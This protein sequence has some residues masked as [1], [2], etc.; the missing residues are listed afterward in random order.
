M[1][2][3]VPCCEAACSAHSSVYACSYVLFRLVFCVLLLLGPCVCACTNARGG[4]CV[5]TCGL[6][7]DMHNSEGACMLV[8][9]S[10]W[11]MSVCFGAPLPLSF[12]VSLPL[13]P[14]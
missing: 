8:C 2:V 12:S 9:V 10:F 3:S 7:C 5:R 1:R 4:F 13:L 11:C 6:S 14:E